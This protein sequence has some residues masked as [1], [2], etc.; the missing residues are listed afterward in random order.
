MASDRSRDVVATAEVVLDRL[1]GAGAG[2]SG[3]AR[4]RPWVSV[5]DEST[6]RAAGPGGGRRRAIRSPVRGVQLASV[7]REAEALVAGQDAAVAEL[8]D[9]PPDGGRR[10]QA[11]QEQVGGRRLRVG[12]AGRQPEDRRPPI[13]ASHSIEPGWA[14]T[15]RRTTRPPSASIARKQGSSGSVLAAARGQDQVRPVRTRART[16]DMRRLDRGDVVLDVFDRRRSSSR[17]PRSSPA[18]SPRTGRGRSR[19][20]TPSRR[21]RRAA[22]RTAAT[23]TSGRLPEPRVARRVDD[24]AASTRCGATLTLATRSPAR[25]SGRRRP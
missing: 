2:G 8:R 22:A 13:R 16:R 25:R 3:R 1:D 14:G 6:R 20:S 5:I 18:R 9:R 15:P 17:A 7:R 12:P 24:R 11:R 10:K 23:H 21:P 19:G 4:S